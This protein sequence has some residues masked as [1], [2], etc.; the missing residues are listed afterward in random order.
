MT[1][2][3]LAVFD[4]DGTLVDS[5]ASIIACVNA[6]WA[7]EGLAPPPA[8]SVRRGVGLRL[9]EAIA[10][11]APDLPLAT[12]G[13]LTDG[14]RHAF[15][16]LRDE[17]AVEEPLYAGIS[18]L[19]DQL[20]AA[21]WLLGIATGKG[22]P[23]LKKTLI[24][25]G[26]ADRFVTLQTADVAAGKPSPDMLHR[27]SAESGVGLDRV[28]MIGDTT[29]DILMARNAGVV[30]VGV[31]WGYHPTDE[32]HAAGADAIVDTAAEIFDAADRL[33]TNR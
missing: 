16:D 17:A 1:D 22:Q 20:E 12:Q 14:Y 29:Y 30:A 23:G 10:R 2:L 27:A 26:L 11:L 8:E 9:D 18:D 32:L 6:A 31:A 15:L 5:Q 3:R 13:R 7:A 24:S 33:V 28:I 21:G 4:C 25:H 19:L